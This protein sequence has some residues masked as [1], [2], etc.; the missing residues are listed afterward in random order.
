MLV[1]D[2]LEILSFEESSVVPKMSLEN[3]KKL[4][5]NP[6]KTMSVQKLQDIISSKLSEA[7]HKYSAVMKYSIGKA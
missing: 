4:D 1:N 5:E 6:L 3:N 7:K 2:L